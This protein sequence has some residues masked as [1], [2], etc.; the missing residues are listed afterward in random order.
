MKREVW[1]ECADAQAGPSFIPI[2]TCQKVPFQTMPIAISTC[3][4]IK[5]I[6]WCERH[7]KSSR[8]AHV[9][10]L[11]LT[12]IQS[13]QS[14]MCVLTV[15]SGLSY[16]DPGS[17]D[18]GH[19]AWDTLADAMLLGLSFRHS[20]IIK[21]YLLFHDKKTWANKNVQNRPWQLR[22]LISWFCILKS[23]GFIDW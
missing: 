13:D 22:N 4:T 15:A 14:S 23:R 1:S 19:T 12:S 3:E 5:P 16:V 2:R 18:S 21:I 8:V 9:T 17:G 10:L 11:A 6:K 20:I 7:V